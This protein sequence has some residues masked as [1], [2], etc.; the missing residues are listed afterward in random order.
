[1]AERGNGVR[2][3][4]KA[5][6]IVWFLIP[7]GVRS[8]DKASEW[9][10]LFNG[11]DLTGFKPAAGD[12]KVNDGAIVNQVNLNANS[13]LETGQSLADFELSGKV[14]VENNGY[15]EVHI[16]GYGQVFEVD[17]ERGAWVDLQIVA[18]GKDI[19][20]LV[21]GKP[22]ARASDGDAGAREGSLGFYA[23]KGGVLKLKSLKLKT[24]Y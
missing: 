16:H 21:D 23:P 15:F 10:D 14:M 12:W 4:L 2:H 3:Y 5:C 20:V 9:T 18:K 24:N 1:M 7:L 8:E 11:K 13:R 6:L 22:G 17:L 19:K